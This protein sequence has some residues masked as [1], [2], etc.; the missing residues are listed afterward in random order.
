MNTY[1]WFYHT[2]Y[3]IGIHKAREVLFP[4][5][6]FSNQ[7]SCI[8]YKYTSCLCMPQVLLSLQHLLMHIWCVQWRQRLSTAQASPDLHFIPCQHP[9]RSIHNLISLR[10]PDFR[11]ISSFP[12]FWSCLDKVPHCDAK[13]SSCE[14]VVRHSP[15]VIVQDF[16]E[17]GS[18]TP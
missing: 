13:L 5:C 18:R 4:V 3:Q 8:W 12:V 10:L 17:H 15:H 9:Q 1:P 7:G 16:T 14:T 11:E 6:C 2:K